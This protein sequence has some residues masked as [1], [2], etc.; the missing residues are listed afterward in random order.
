MPSFD[1]NHCIMSLDLLVSPGRRR[2]VRRRLTFALLTRLR[3]ELTF[4]RNGFKWTGPTASCITRLI[5]VDDHYQDRYL[6]PITKWLRANTDFSRPTVVNIGANLGDVA[7]PLSRTGKRVIAIEPNPESF[8]RL[9]QNVRQNGLAGRVQCY[10]IAIS[11]EPGSADLVLAG[12]PGNSELRG[13]GDKI[14]FNGVDVVC[15]V[16]PVKTMRLE[17]LMQSLGIPLAEVGLVWSDT[18][19]Y[20][21]QV[22]SSA[23]GLW[24]NGTP[25]WV[26]IW[27]KGLDC[28]GGA[29][30]FIE[31]CN[32]YFKRI[33][34][35]DRLGDEPQPIDA[36]AG[37]VRDL[38]S[39]AYTDGLL[40]P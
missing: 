26:E 32:Q 37:V 12:D 19:G 18:Q 22:I 17:T 9:Q 30:R 15:G 8:A 13:V 40:I 29:D 35:A 27:P 25:L 36:L 23:P 7:L 33:L 24:K 21:S 39:G 10:E 2:A 31:V 28:H 34:I 38:K 6:E 16:V 3:S 4:R 14:G 20:E 1:M 5:F 11:D